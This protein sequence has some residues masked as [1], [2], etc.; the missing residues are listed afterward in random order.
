MTAFRFIA[1][2][3]VAVAVALLGADAVSSLEKGVPV[4]RTTGTILE[5]F[6]INGRGIADVAPGGVSQAI[7]TLLGVPLWA[8]MGLIGVVLTLVFRPMD[9]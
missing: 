4:V 3:L 9:D 5:L 8:V 2:V 6:G 7:V 1:W